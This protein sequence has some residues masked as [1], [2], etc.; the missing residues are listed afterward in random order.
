MSS[1]C[2][3]RNSSI[4]FQVSIHCAPCFYQNPSSAPVQWQPLFAPSRTLPPQR[5]DVVDQLVANALQPSPENDPKK[6]TRHVTYPC[7]TYFYNPTKQ[8]Q[9][10]HHGKTLLCE[11]I[12][13][14][15]PRTGRSLKPCTCVVWS[16]PSIVPDFFQHRV[17]VL[18]PVLPTQPHFMRSSSVGHSLQLI[19]TTRLVIIDPNSPGIS[20]NTKS[21]ARVACASPK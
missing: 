8:Y 5:S 12:D 6:D 13:D 10:F 4:A 7:D 11:A 18:K 2:E 9:S 17:S 14:I 3:L 20:I 19:A 16:Y 1:S 21:C 15:D